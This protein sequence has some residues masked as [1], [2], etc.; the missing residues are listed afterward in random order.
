MNIRRIAWL[1]VTSI[2]VASWFSAASTPDLRTPSLVERAPSTR[3]LDRSAA[4]MQSEVARLQDRI[5]PTATPS[6]ARDLFRFAGRA[7]H[8]ATGAPQRPAAQDTE[9]PAET[10]PK[11]TLQLIGVAED[12]SADGMVRTAI[13]AGLGDLFLVKPGDVVA[14]Q[15]LV[16]RV[17]SD[18]VQLTDTSTSAS[19]TLTLH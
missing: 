7:P 13:V 5:A 15:Y 8:P 10:P 18:A 19:T 11:P 16:E 9:A 4:T 17:T 3:E 6:H 12:E 1:G 2:A 14:G